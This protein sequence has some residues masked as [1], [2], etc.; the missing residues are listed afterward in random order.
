M[1]SLTEIAGYLLV[2]AMRCATQE[3]GDAHH[4]SEVAQYGLLVE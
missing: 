4:E 3:A 1:Q 2:H